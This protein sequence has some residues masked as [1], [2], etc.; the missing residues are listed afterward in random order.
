M[1]PE[2]RFTDTVQA[3]TQYRPG[4]P[5]E[6]LPLLKRLEALKEDAIIAD[7]GSGT[8]ILTAD[9]LAAGHKVYGIEPNEAMR[10]EAERALSQYERFISVNGRAESTSLG[11][12]S[13]DLITIAT[14][15]HWLDPIQTKTECLRLL[16][17]K[18]Y[19]ALI[20]NIRDIYASPLMHEY[21]SILERYAVD[22]QQTASQRYDESIIQ[23]FFS[24]NHFLIETMPNEQHFDKQGLVGRAL[25]TSYAPRKDSNKLNQMIKALEHCFDLYQSNGGITFAYQTKVYLGQLDE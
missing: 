22:Y 20:W 3:Y 21:E 1:K 11:S 10:K 8:G 12:H 13:V 25:S 19:V 17:P 2:E 23:D 24:P 9:F 4:Y 18:G 7:I 5:A 6:L 15:F 14:A 16:T